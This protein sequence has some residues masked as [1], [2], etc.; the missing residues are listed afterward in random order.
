MNRAKGF[1]LVEVVVSAALVGLGLAAAI[2]GYSS[3]SESDL[4]LRDREKIQRLAFDKY[5][6]LAA[7][8]QLTAS[9]SGDFA[10]RN[11]TGYTWSSD[12]VATGTTDLNEIKVTVKKENSND[13][14][15]LDALSFA[16]AAQ[17]TT[18]ATQ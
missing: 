7:T 17:T 15:E 1:T 9:L 3:L 14:Y 2:R 11:L 4:R 8:G 12:V 5:N 16:P 10:D 6:E 18:G 13:S